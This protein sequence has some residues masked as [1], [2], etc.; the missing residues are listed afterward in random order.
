[1]SYLAWAHSRAPGPLHLVDI[2][3]RG[4]PPG[5]LDAWPGGVVG[6]GVDPDAAEIDRLRPKWP[7]IRFTPAWIEAP[8][9][10]DTLPQG[11]DR[12]TW[13]AVNN[14]TWRRT[15][16]AAAQ[17][18]ATMEVA[19]GDP[20]QLV[21]PPVPSRTVDEVA[22]E[23]ARIDVVKI[24]T[25]GHDLEVIE[26]GPATLDSALMVSIE[27]QLQGRPHARAGTFGNLDAALRARGFELFDLVTHRHSRAALPAPFWGGGAGPTF[28]GQTVWGDAV[29]ARDLVGTPD[30]R[31]TDRVPVLA[32][33]FAMVGLPDCGAELWQQQGGPEATEAIA[34]LSQAWWRDGGR[35]ARATLAAA[36][37]RLRRVEG[38]RGAR[39][40]LRT[41]ILWRG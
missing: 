36:P 14:A 3:C 20:G 22:A 1:M 25:D 18:A 4:G 15:S 31:F 7:K 6:V 26:S 23:L 12:A 11:F 38:R 33:L 29:Y 5:W 13:H 30:A 41:R 16:S 17:V 35:W 39:L 40:P 19:P 10:P 24:D 8:H 2:G 21:G 32:A 9:F 34:A 27:V 37:E 28:R